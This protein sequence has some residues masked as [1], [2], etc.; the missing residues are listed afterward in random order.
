MASGTLRAPWE[1]DEGMLRV[2]GFFV[3]TVA[4]LTP[5]FSDSTFPGHELTTLG[6]LH[7]LLQRELRDL[8]DPYP[9]GSETHSLDGCH[10]RGDTPRSWHDGTL[11]NAHCV[12]SYF[13]ITT[14]PL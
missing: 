12:R 4:E 11:E 3:A 1:I 6:A 9:S 2:S 7:D 8:D 14:S 10:T 13:G 5:L